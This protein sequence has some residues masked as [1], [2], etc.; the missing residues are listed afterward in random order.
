MIGEYQKL[1]GLDFKKEKLEVNKLPLYLTSGRSFFRLSYNNMKFI[2][3]CVSADE[4]YG[5]IAFEK[6][7]KLIREKYGLPAAFGFENLGYS[8]L[9]NVFR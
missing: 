8:L 9:I 7:E 2:L 6:Q 4:K 5:V 3:V 1:F